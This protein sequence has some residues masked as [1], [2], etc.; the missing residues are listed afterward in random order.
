MVN[1][2]Y[3]APTVA[4]GTEDGVPTASGPLTFKP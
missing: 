4:T 3:A 1:P 2:A